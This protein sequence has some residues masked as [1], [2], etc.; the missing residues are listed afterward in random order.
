LMQGRG[1]SFQGTVNISWTI[2]FKLTKT[3]KYG[4][5]HTQILTGTTNSKWQNTNSTSEGVSKDGRS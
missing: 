4:Q 2:E 5:L 3:E 1:K